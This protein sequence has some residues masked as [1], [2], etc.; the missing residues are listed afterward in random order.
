MLFWPIFGNFWCPVVTPERDTAVAVV[1]GVV[2]VAGQYFSFLI[3]GL[4]K[5]LD[6]YVQDVKRHYSTSFWWYDD[7]E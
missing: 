1:A 3:L 7:E 6:I 4:L 5:M 2:V